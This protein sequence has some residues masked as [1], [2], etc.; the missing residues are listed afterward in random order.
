MNDINKN[1]EY[2]SATHPNGKVEY[3]SSIL[4]HMWKKITPIFKQEKDVKK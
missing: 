3:F 2:Y 4:G 1:V